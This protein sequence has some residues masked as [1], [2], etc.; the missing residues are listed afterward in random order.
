MTFP[1][2]RFTVRRMMA[3]VAVAA[4]VSAGWVESARMEAAM[5][6]WRLECSLRAI[7]HSLSASIHS[8]GRW[9][10]RLTSPPSEPSVIDPKKAAYHAAMARKWSA[11]ADRP[12]LAVEPDPPEPN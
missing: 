8:G 7:D 10:C 1:R 2:V 12:W 11:A 5:E 9:P 3:A 4:L 6:E